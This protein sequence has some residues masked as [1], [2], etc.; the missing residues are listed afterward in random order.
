MTEPNEQ[1]PE[2]MTRESIVEILK[3]NITFSG[4]VGDYVIHGAIDKILELHNKQLS[5]HKKLISELL[6][7]A[8]RYKNEFEKLSGGAFADG[9]HE[10]IARAK[11][12]LGI[13]DPSE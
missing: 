2:A 11:L 13:V 4:Q 3:D 9:S 8:E 6:P 10:V 1:S 7:I 12:K 5:D